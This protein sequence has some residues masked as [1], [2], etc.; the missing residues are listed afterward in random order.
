MGSGDFTSGMRV[1]VVILALGLAGCSWFRSKPVSQT[2]PRTTTQQGV[3]A[4]GNSKLIVTPET[5][6]IGKV[7]TVNATARFVVLTFPVGR[8]PAV[9]AQLSVYRRGLK[10]G[11]VKITSMHLDDNVVADLTDGDAEAGDE[12]REK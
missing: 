8:L 2:A 3:V 5:A 6:L 9:D 1:L 4:G 11:E 7:A 12:V 10:I